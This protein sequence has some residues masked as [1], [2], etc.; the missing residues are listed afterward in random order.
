MSA[1]VEYLKLI[2]KGI[3]NSTLI[4][5]SVVNQVK[6]KLDMLPEEDKET[7][8]SRRIICATCPFM[9]K[10]ATTSK[11]FKELVGYNYKTHRADEH[12]SFC[13]CGIST[14]TSGMANDCGMETWN[15]D[16]PNNKQPLKWQ[17]KTLLEK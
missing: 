11:E 2:P 6:L 4:V 7:I 8:I 5:E 13:G 10:N 9:S 3:P 12:C 15:R 1:I 16:N 17:K 14:R